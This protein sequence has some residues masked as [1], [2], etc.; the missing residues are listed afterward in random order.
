MAD[1]IDSGKISFACEL[2]KDLE[3][4]TTE[5][6]TEA[7]ITFTETQIVLGLGNDKSIKYKA[8]GQ[9][10]D[11]SNYYNKSQVDE[12]LKLKIDKTQLGDY[13]NK[14]EIDTSLST[15][16]DTTTLTTNHYN[17]T[18]TDNLLNNKADKT[19]LENYYNKSD[20]DGKLTNKVD[21]TTL[22]NYDLSTEVDNKVKVVSDKVGDLSTL[23]TGVKDTVV[24][25]INEVKR[26]QTEAG[27][28][29]N[30]ND[31]GD[32]NASAPRRGQFLGWDQ[33]TSKWISKDVET[34]GMDTH[35]ADFSNPHRT[36]ISNLNDTTI[37]T[38]KANQVLVYNGTQWI[39]KDVSLDD[40]NYAK[41]NATNTFTGENTF[42]NLKVTKD[43]TEAEEAVNLRTLQT[44][45]G[46]IDYSNF[47]KKNE[48][49]VFTKKQSGIDGTEDANFVTLR[50]LKTKV[51]L[52][53][54]ETIA[55]NKTF[56]SPVS[57][58]NAT[59]NNHSLPLG[60][61]DGRYA[62]L[63]T[64]DLQWTVSNEAES[65]TNFNDL[66]KAINEASK[67]QP[68]NGYN[69]ITIT[70][71]TD[72]VWNKII[73]IP[74][75]S[76]LSFIKI[77]S[78]TTNNCSV[79]DTFLTGSE[80]VTPYLGMKLTCV[81]GAKILFSRSTVR[82][83]SV[84]SINKIR[85]LAL[86]VCWVESDGGEFNFEDDTNDPTVLVIE[87]CFGYFY[88][89][90]NIKYNYTAT[91][92]FGFLIQTN[93]CKLLMDNDVTFNITANPLSTIF[94]FGLSRITLDIDA[95]DKSTTKYITNCKGSLYNVVFGTHLNTHQKII[96]EGS[97]ENI[98][99]NIDDSGNKVNIFDPA[100]ITLNQCRYTNIT[101][102]QLTQGGSF[103]TPKGA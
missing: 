15:K 77:L 53:G 6:N 57:I 71:K 51:G 66:Q 43:A 36:T 49:N 29:T 20:I 28:V 88:S 34:D 2:D 26:A 23:E 19:V 99:F 63:L 80:C 101:P 54:N 38:P 98:C 65:D 32:V 27:K 5:S 84:I 75:G 96:I 13:Y 60:Q 24:S 64:Q 47:A 3:T 89:K 14:S 102:G 67:Y 68:A 11:L 76:N 83:L 17:K 10:T 86:N 16:V 39:N 74:T 44:K 62:K 1:M 61:A 72:W 92:I 9:G 58:P 94:G 4:P 87:R 52:T 18:E 33:D 100:K 97:T 46:E 31:L 69:F 73:R 82:F 79:S 42:N 95:G 7:R 35:M 45:I 78:E 25:A 90:I 21:T 85:M 59:A 12:K 70:L 8:T 91:Q 22:D 50:Q 37:N 93:S 55:G 30:L 48:A 41:K 81:K 103:I 56:S 40:S